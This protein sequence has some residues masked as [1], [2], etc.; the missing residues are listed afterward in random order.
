MRFLGTLAA[1][2][3]P[4]DEA[5]AAALEALVAH[6]ADQ[7][8]ALDKVVR[9]R[10]CQ[11]LALVLGGLPETEGVSEELAEGLEEGLLERLQDKAPLVRAQAARALARLP[12]PDEVRPTSSDS[13][14]ASQ[15]WPCAQI[16]W[17]LDCWQTLYQSHA[18]QR[19]HDQVW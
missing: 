6:L 18:V 1:H 17:L 19:L 4:S 13:T 8:Q 10:A 3:P 7:L 14:R 11:A 15:L 9:F 16:R 5:C 2:M 12:A